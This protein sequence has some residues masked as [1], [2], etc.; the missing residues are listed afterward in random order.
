MGEH[1]TRANL[2]LGVRPRV[3]LLLPP[4]EPG[5]FSTWLV[6]ELPGPQSAERPEGRHLADPRLP[7]SE[8]E[9]RWGES[10]RP[11]RTLATLTV[12]AG[13]ETWELEQDAHHPDRWRLCGD[14]RRHWS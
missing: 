9:L 12:I 4:D 2:V 13:G 5:A 10:A 8:I 1:P 6:V 14:D 11:P 7:E 3:E